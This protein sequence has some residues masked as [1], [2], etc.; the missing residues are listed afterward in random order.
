MLEI[1]KLLVSSGKKEILK[2]INLTIK[3]GETHVVMGPNGSGKSTLSL[4]LMGHPGYQVT[5]GK[6]LLDG[7]DITTLSP[8]KRAKLGLFL[9]M[10]SPVA[11]PGVSVLNLIRTASKNLTGKAPD[12]LKFI[13]EIK[14]NLQDLKLEETVMS[15]S[16]HES[17]SG[18][19]KKKVEILQLAMLKP[20]YLILD[21]TDSGLDVDALKI[22]G[23]G[24]KKNATKKRGVLLITH[25]QRIL[26][27][28]KPDYV[29]ILVNGKIV[30]SGDF[31]LA[32]RIEEKGYVGVG[33]D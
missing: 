32:S 22:V 27:Y 17:F 31:K 3:A 2:G 23:E 24:I 5:S 13:S 16:I 28:V 18:G 14:N 21:E 19:E 33:N 4:A 15:R 9:S 12:P 1:K 20:K 29:H 26:K 11:I 7:K 25:Y 8:D 6:I 30:E 10:Q